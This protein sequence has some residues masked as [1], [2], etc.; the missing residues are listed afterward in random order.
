M[1]KTLSLILAL[2]MMLSCFGAFAEG[3]SAGDSTAE[4]TGEQTAMT[5]ADVIDAANATANTEAAAAAA[6]ALEADCPYAVIP[7]DETTGQIQLSY[8]PEVTTILE[9]DGLKFK[10]LN[11]N[12]SLDVYEDW[13]KDI[14]TRIADIL[15]Q[16]TVEE[17]AGLL[18]CVN[19]QLADAVQM[20]QKWSLTC[21]L[22]NLNGTPITITNTLNNLQ[23]AAEAE[24]LGVPMVF[25]S[26]REYNSFGGYID[27]S[28][29]AFGTANDPELA[30]KLAK[31][32][33]QAMDAIGVHVTFEP[34]ANEIGAQYGE[35]PELIASIIAAEIRG[36]TE[37]GLTSCTKHWI[38]R[39][40]DSSF[41]GARS[42]AQN[43][44]NWLEG[45]TAALENG[46]GWVM[47]NCGGTGLTNTV[48]V[49]FDSVTMGYLRE[50]LGF[51]GVVVTDW[52]AFGGG[53]SNPG[54]M[55]GITPEGEDLAT[56]DIYW[57]FNRALELGTDMFGSGSMMDSHE[58]WEQSPSSNYPTALIQGIKEGT[59]EKKWVD[60]S[61]TRILR[62]KFEK[63]LFEDP[64]NSVAHAVEVC[65]SLEWAANP[66][67]PSSNEELRAARN[68]VEVALTEEL[69]AKSAVLVKNDNDLLPLKQG[70][71]VYIDA[72]ATA[73]KNAYITYI[74][75][76]A[77][78]VDKMEDADV[79]IGDYGSVN[80][81]C[82]LFLDDAEYYN[83]PV[84]LTL[85]N[86]DPTQ[87]ALENADAVM[88]LSYNQGADHG[89]SEAGFVMTTAGWVYA[90]LLF[91]VKEPGGI[92]V[93]EIARDS[94]KDSLQW[95]DLAGD[96]GADPYVRLIVQALME[97][98]P[99]HA[100]PNNYGDPLVQYHYGMTYG[101]QPE[102]KYSCLIVP[103]TVT[104]E[105]VEGSSGSTSIQTTVT[106]SAKAGEP[107]T[108]YC[109][110]RNNGSDGITT[111][112]AYANDV[113]VNEKIMT[114]CGG[115]W[116]VVQMDL[117]LEAGEYTLNV[118]GLTAN[119]TVQ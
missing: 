71:K 15:A 85:N 20:V 78:I 68:P 60:R 102:F 62:D 52:W 2:M 4:A 11:K 76:Y 7:A 89:S 46:T 26:D 83:V 35:N 39:G 91:G 53:P 119:I 29:E 103:Q 28:H 6:A 13:T 59:I 21:Q 45:W 67:A 118:G 8:M 31:Y 92:I 65:A 56:K 84:V 81:A 17:E 18:F 9:V 22:F 57:L 70:I 33:G 113:L 12:G 106:N 5:A 88:Y 82:E 16:M 100:S 41:G 36:L 47:T 14:D 54:R 32:Y 34:Y 90:D 86:T 109:L 49:K 42:V 51:D 27:K 116:R 43:F 50:T 93:K 79:A 23:A 63:G 40:G 80:D 25:T 117:I 72:S 110:L 115:S 74:A 112:E 19:T 44:D 77:T 37:G 10:D 73:A 30:Y 1:K 66:V 87:Y 108:V 48:D 3:E 95:Q 101:K 105:E 75:Q 96:Q 98:D 24:R 97:D 64:Y 104:Q 94:I 114:V 55:S 111:V 107:F 38:G 61:A 99:D 69:M 58:N